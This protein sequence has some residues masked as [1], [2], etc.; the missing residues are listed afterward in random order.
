MATLRT[1]YWY[2]SLYLKKHAKIIIGAIVLGILLFAILLPLLTNLPQVKPTRY[3]GIIG[4]YDFSSLPLSIQ[5]QISHGLTR[6]EEDGSAGPDLSERWSIEDEGKTYRFILKNDVY[7]QDGKRLEPSDI[8]FN[9]Q[10]TQIVTTDNEIIFKLQDSF[11]PFPIVVS[12]P[13]FR[14]TETSYLRFLKRKKIVGL[15]VYSV[16]RTSYQ[17]NRL[18]ELVLDSPKERIIYRFFL[19]EDRAKVAFKHG[20]IDEIK[21]LS[22]AQEFEDWPNISITQ[23]I[24]TNQYLGLFFNQDDPLFEKNIRQG[25][26]YALTKSDDSIRAKGPINPTSWAY[27]DGVKSYAFDIERGIERMLDK[28][29][30][31]PMNISLVTTQRFQPDAEEIKKEWEAFGKQVYEACQ[32]SGNV[33]DKTQCE[34]VNITVNIVVTN[35]PDL[36][37]YQAILVGQQIPND[38]DQYSLW[39][40]TQNTNFTHYKN[41]RIDSLLETGRTETDQNERKA[42]YQ[43]FQQFLLEDAP[44]IFLHYLESYN[45]QRK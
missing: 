31:A 13:L 5:N 38:P 9:F 3:V 33:E 8:S 14:E 43:E 37:N 4:G 32:Q 36:S 2:I 17:D 19:T 41:P 30:P 23:N 12:Q 45:V 1:S 29:P 44:A 35:F 26:S 34:N 27:L 15:G 6:I 11:A 22:N 16:S 28:L 40:S 7:W 20:R 25:L 10:D 21:D 39:D 24:N 42:I 18:S